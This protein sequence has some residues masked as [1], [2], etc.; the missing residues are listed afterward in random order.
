MRS[1]RP[2]VFLTDRKEIVLSFI[3]KYFSFN[4]RTP[5]T[6]TVRRLKAG[7]TFSS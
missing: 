4:Q 7:K 5:I 6:Q 3:W 2:C 1:D